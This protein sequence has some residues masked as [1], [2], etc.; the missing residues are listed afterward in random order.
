[1]SHTVSGLHGFFGMTQ[2]TYRITMGRH[3]LDSSGSE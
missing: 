1:M 2:A 3:Q